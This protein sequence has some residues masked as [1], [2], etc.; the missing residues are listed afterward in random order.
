MKSYTEKEGAARGSKERRK[1]SEEG[2]SERLSKDFFFLMTVSTPVFMS[3]TAKK[4][5]KRTVW[6]E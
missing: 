1:N 4:R 5:K 3:R 6:K 2:S